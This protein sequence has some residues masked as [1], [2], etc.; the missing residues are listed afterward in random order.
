MKAKTRNLLT[1]AAMAFVA[2]NFTSCKEEDDE[3]DLSFENCVSEVEDMSIKDGDIICD[4]SINLY[5]LK[6][7]VHT[8]NKDVEGGSL[9]KVGTSKEN[10]SVVETYEIEL[11]P[12]A[13]YYV[14]T[15]PYIVHENDT[16]FGDTKEIKFYSIP[17]HDLALTA[18]YGDGDIAA[19]IHWKLQYYYEDEDKDV[20][21]PT[22]DNPFEEDFFSYEHKCHKYYECNNAVSS[23]SVNMITDYDTVYNKN[24]IAFPGNVDSCYI[25]Q[26]GTRERPDYPAYIYR[27]WKDGKTI[28]HYDPVIYDFCINAA[29]PVGE[30]TIN[31]KDTIRGI[32]MDKQNCVCDYEFNIYRIAKIGNKVWTLDDYR[33]ATINE[34]SYKKVKDFWLID[35][36]GYNEFLYNPSVTGF[37]INVRKYEV[38]YLNG[39]H[40]ANQEDWEDLFT[41]FGINA[42]P[43]TLKVDDKNILVGL[44][45]ED[46]TLNHYFATDG[47]VHELFSSYGWTDSV[48]NFTETY[49]GIFN[50]VP[51]GVLYDKEKKFSKGECAFFRSIGACYIISKNFGGVAIGKSLLDYG[52]IRFVKD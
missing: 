43:D 10:M 42:K 50:A 48:G 33:G 7:F 22:S 51:K 26:G 44:E 4:K 32:L 30:N 21:E 28:M 17:K 49:Q 37:A 13:V 8:N 16:T 39:Y 47:A 27:Y 36:Y 52:S 18:D 40:I 35:F 15:T 1:I 6:I 11:E 14:E 2:L 19:N 12:F 25:A 9:I 45:N 46:T 38:N 34:L 20:Y 24:A 41:Y 29:I 5:K 23:V 31:V 3:F